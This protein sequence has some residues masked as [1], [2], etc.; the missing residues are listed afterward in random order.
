[1]IDT[2]D[3]L[4]IHRVLRREIGA[5]PGLLRAAAGNPA[6]AKLVGAHTSEML[7]FLHVHH[8]GEDKLIWP[9][10]RSRVTI[11]DDLLERMEAQHEQVAAAVAEVRRELP[12]WT[13]SG[14][15]G[16]GERIATQ[17]DEM[18]EVLTAHL[19]EEE[20]RILPLVAA[21]FSKDEWEALAKHGFGAI[22]GKRRLFVLGHILEETDENERKTFLLN[23]PPPARLAFKLVGRRHWAREVAVIRG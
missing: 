2:H 13:E 8:S 17:F 11:G 9:V 4:L 14:D 16:V 6:R 1:M 5:L 3:M 19:A 15:A 18:L 22:P 21:N 23:V 7:E 20:E 12:G 10:L